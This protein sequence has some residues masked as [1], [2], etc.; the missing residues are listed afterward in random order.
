ML[1][2]SDQHLP[3]FGLISLACLCMA[4][5]WYFWPP[6]VVEDNACSQ[7]EQTLQ[8]QGSYFLNWNAPQLV[9]VR[10]VAEPKMLQVEA[11]NKTDACRELQQQLSQ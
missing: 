1:L 10:P 3:R 2:K 11:D 6:G 5:I 9:L 8:T 4:G 7:L